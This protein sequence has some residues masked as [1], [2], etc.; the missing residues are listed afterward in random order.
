MFAKAMFKGASQAGE[1]TVG[2]SLR[3]NDDDSAYLSRTP[4]SAGNRKTWTWSGWVKRGNLSSDFA[5]FGCTSNETNSPTADEFYFRFNNDNSLYMQGYI[6][7]YQISLKTTPLYRDTSAWYH[8]VVVMDTSNATASDRVKFY[9]NGERIT[10][11]V[12]STYPSQNHEPTWNSTFVHKIGKVANYINNYFDGY[13]AD[14]YFI[15]GQALGPTSFGDYDADGYWKP[16]K[17]SGTFG[18]NGFYLPFKVGDGWSAR[19]DGSSDGVRTTNT[20]TEFAYGTGDFTIEGWI[21]APDQTNAFICDTR[22]GFASHPHVTTGSVTSG[23]LRYGNTNTESTTKICD[24]TW[25]HFAITRQSGSVKLWVD[26]VLENTVTDTSSYG[27]NYSTI[28]TNSYGYPTNNNLNGYLSNFRVVKGTAVYTSNFTPSTTPLTAIAGT[29]ILTFQDSTI[30]DNSTNSLA[31][32]VSGNTFIDKLSPFST[33]YV[34]D[35]SGNEN[36][37]FPSALINHTDVVDDTPSVNYA[38]W[39]PL[40]LGTDATLSDGSLKIAYGSSIT[41]NAT[42]STFG[43]TSGKWYWETEITASSLANTSAALGISISSSSSALPNY[44]GFNAL[45]WGYEGN[46]GYK[47]HNASGVAYGATY[48]VGDIIGVAFDADTGALEFYKNNVSQGVAYT[49]LTNGPY[50]PAIGDGSAG[51]TFTAVSNFGQ[52]PFAYTPPAGYKALNSKNLPK[53][54]ILDGGKHFDTALYTGNGTSQTITGLGFQP[55][56]VWLKSRNYSHFHLL[57]DS[58]RGNTKFLTTNA[59]STEDTV[60]SGT[61]I[62]PTSDG[63]SVQYSGDW[64]S[65]N[66]SGRDIVAWTWNAGGTTVTNTNGSITSS[67]RAN[68]DAGI[69]IVSWT[70]NASTNQTIGHGLGQDLD[71]VIVKNRSSTTVW[72]VWHSGLSGDTYYLGLN[73][74]FGEYSSS[75]IFNGHSNTTFTIGTDPSVNANGNS[76]IAYCFHSVDGFSKFG[77]YTGNGSTDGPF[78]YTGFRPAFVMVKRTDSTGNWLIQNNKTLGYNP[79]NSELYA[80]LTNTEITADR[81][82]FLSNGFKARIN[83]VENNTNGGTYI[84]MAFAENP[85]KKARAR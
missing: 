4:A 84:F 15:D 57:M 16:K 43:M 82:D 63:F 78:V 29:A 9:V 41:R 30:V 67:V 38:T 46:Q 35:R 13:M 69:S 74:S 44:P 28:G 33:G 10:N 66:T 26:G 19:F 80:N 47:Y 27:S 6:G 7:A 81:A 53:P 25:H 12:T 83:S 5:L 85:F 58:V 3:F 22:G 75:T 34:Q 31:L 42:I 48:S 68:T 79:S 61:G 70:G 65:L 59:T 8:I 54:A 72:R 77:S 40:A 73:Q 2:E 71:M 45:G 50:F 62:V 51:N 64:N 60:D 17:Y 1:Y 21:N 36:D 20:G 23:T 39:N 76:M 37:W 32:T 55:D 11:F 56:I 52:R 24:G 18:T 14:V 49:G